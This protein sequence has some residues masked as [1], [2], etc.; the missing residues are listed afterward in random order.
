[1]STAVDL[2]SCDREPIHV[3]GAIQPFGA[4]LVLDARGVLVRRSDNAGALLRMAQVIQPAVQRAPPRRGGSA[5]QG[6]APH[7]GRIGVPRRDERGRPDPAAD[8]GPD[9][10]VQERRNRSGLGLGLHIVNEIVKSH[11]GRIEIDQ[12]GSVTF[13][14]VF[15]MR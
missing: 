5:D 1:V 3:P 15:P 12:G 2:T 6:L 14:V 8:A 4:L 10:P 13:R 9:L 7:P 11:A